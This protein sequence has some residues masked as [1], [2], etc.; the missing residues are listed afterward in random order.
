MSAHRKIKLGPL[1]FLPIFTLSKTDVL[2]IAFAVFLIGMAILPTVIPYFTKPKTRDYTFMEGFS[3]DYIGYVSY[4]KAAMYGRNYAVIRSLPSAGQQPTTIHLL[5]ILIGKIGKLAGFSPMIAYHV[6]RVILGLSYVLT[7]YF[8]FKVLLKKNAK[9]LA[10][11]I[12]AFFASSISWF[13]PVQGKLEYFSH[14]FVTFSTNLVLRAMSRPHYDGANILFIVISW[15]V[16]FNSVTGIRTILMTILSFVLGIVHAPSAIIMLITFAITYGI[17]VLTGKMTR[18]W[19][20]KFMFV[21]IGLGMGLLLSYVGTQHY[22]WRQ[23]YVTW[24]GIPLDQ[25]PSYLIAFGPI[26]WFGYAGLVMGAFRHRF[27]DPYLYFFIWTSV[28]FALFFY[29]H[30]FLKAENVRFIQAYVCI[31]PLTFGY[32]NILEIITVKKPRIIWYAGMAVLVL[33]S[34][35]QYVFNLNQMIFHGN[36]NFK[37]YSAFVFPSVNMVAAYRF[38]DNYTPKESVVLAYFEAAHNILIYSHNFVIGNRQG[39]SVDG[40]QEMLA[41]RD[42]ILGGVMEKEEMI[43]FFKQYKVQY[44][45]GGYQESFSDVFTKY[46]DIFDPVYSNSEVTIYKVK[47]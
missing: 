45:Y 7:V 16:I 26:L 37:E 25:L 19:Y 12:V 27:K 22:P 46:K 2:A 21:S 35:S 23:V 32:A 34:I 40:Q 15:M 36:T 5:Y 41:K 14:S 47:T 3:D 44:V 9:A 42:Q 10:C 24:G 4:V 20:V 11:T 18:E 33:L 38:L 30:K 1:K 13:I 8:L 43:S 29:F 17:K 6:A 31:V 39:W 28:Q